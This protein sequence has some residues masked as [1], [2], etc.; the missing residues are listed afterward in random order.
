MTIRAIVPGAS[1]TAS[2]TGAGTVNPPLRRRSPTVE[3]HR[4]KSIPRS[5][6]VGGTQQVQT[7]SSGSKSAKRQPTGNYSVGYAQ[8][9]VHS[10][11]APGNPG[12]PGRRNGSRS[13]D[14]IKRSEYQA[15]QTVNF[16]GRTVKLSQRELAEKIIV[17]K[18]LETKDTKLLLHLI[19]EAKRLFPETAPTDD[20]HATESSSELDHQILR[21]ML[22]TFV[23]GER[24][25]DDPDPF[26]SLG[27]AQ[28]DLR[29]NFEGGEWDA[30]PGGVADYAE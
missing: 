10:R 23:M 18:A 6:E 4:S 7:K 9:P 22:A 21:D 25:P 19:Q 2:T 24:D 16:A 11:F 8:P 1:P 15:K 20:T 27:I 12:G 30:T 28:P 17:K 29:A 5:T 13:L 26:S 3:A 14:S